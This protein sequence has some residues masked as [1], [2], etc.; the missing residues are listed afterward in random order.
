[1]NTWPDITGATNVQI[2][3]W[4]EAQSWAHEMAA[5]QQDDQWHAEGDVWTHT[6]MVCAEVE[7]L[8]RE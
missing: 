8:P 7:R 3:A 2:L 1:M 5:C 4:T 6:R